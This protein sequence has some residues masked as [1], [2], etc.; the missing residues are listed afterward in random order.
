[1]RAF[2]G[3]LRIVYGFVFHVFCCFNCCYVFCVRL[4]KS[5]HVFLERSAKDRYVETEDFYD[6][7]PGESSTRSSPTL[8]EVKTC[9]REERRFRKK[10]C[11]L[12][13]DGTSGPP[14]LVVYIMDPHPKILLVAVPSMLKLL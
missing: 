10:A 8:R 9:F 5:R 11:N 2:C 13:L 6:I 3:S 14:S 1:M 4:R 7:A 12:R